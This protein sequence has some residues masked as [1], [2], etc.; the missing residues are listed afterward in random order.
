MTS[1]PIRTGIAAAAATGAFALA[2]CGSDEDK[3]ATAESA[4]PPAPTA[5][6]EAA[7]TPAPAAAAA[8]AALRGRWG[9]PVREGATAAPIPL[10][11]WRLD[12]AKRA[13][14]VY[15]P[16]N[17]T[18]D[19]TMQLSV[20]GRRL[21]VGPAP[22]CTGAGTYT[23]RASD[24]RLRLAVVEDACTLRASLFEGAWTRAR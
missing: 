12:V 11:V 19:F 23:W 18:I 17:D 15:A 8:P 13:M 14:D 22:A 16:R 4:R 7:A 2:G 24:R 9:R 3:T 20:D 1:R 21:T 10:G 6:P 5:T